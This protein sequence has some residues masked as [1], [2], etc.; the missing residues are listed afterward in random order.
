MIGQTLGHYRMVEK[1]GKGSM[2]V[3]YRTLMRRST[4]KPE[5]IR[6]DA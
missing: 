6:D 2:S 5:G 4:A 1:L 3:L